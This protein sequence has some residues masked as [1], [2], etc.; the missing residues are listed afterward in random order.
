MN[1]S[2]ENKRHLVKPHVL[3]T[4]RQSFVDQEIVNPRKVEK[5]NGKN[6]KGSCPEEMSTRTLI[7]FKWGKV[8]CLSRWTFKCEGL[9]S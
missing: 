4:Q 1:T 2:S 5:G 3:K 8:T 7:A 6:A 9:P